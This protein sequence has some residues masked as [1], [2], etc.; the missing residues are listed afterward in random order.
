[1]RHSIFTSSILISRFQGAKY[2]CHE[3][4]EKKRLRDQ[5]NISKIFN[6]WISIEK[7]LNVLQHW[8]QFYAV[9][10]KPLKM[11]K[12][13]RFLLQ[14]LGS[15]GAYMTPLW[16]PSDF[17]YIATVDCS[18]HTDLDREV[19]LFSVSGLFSKLIQELV[20]HT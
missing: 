11:R 10:W 5:Q 18:V 9:H 6:K 13:Y 8:K 2:I 19:S 17:G 4:Q 7:R 12:I 1:M 14:I 3:F 16:L 20:Q 15:F